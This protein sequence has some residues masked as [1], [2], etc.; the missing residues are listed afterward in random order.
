MFSSRGANQDFPFGEDREGHVASQ[1]SS[2]KFGDQRGTHVK[3]AAGIRW[4]D[5]QCHGENVSHNKF[6]AQ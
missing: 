2:P 5:L 3:Y 6:I 4:T 1:K